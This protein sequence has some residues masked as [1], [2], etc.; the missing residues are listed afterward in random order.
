MGEPF[1]IPGEGHCPPPPPPLP[2][3]PMPVPQ[4]ISPQP[5]PVF[6]SHAYPQPPDQ[7][8]GLIETF[9]PCPPGEVEPPGMTDGSCVMFP[10]KTVDHSHC[11]PPKSTFDTEGFNLQVQ[12]GVPCVPN[13]SFRGQSGNGSDDE[14]AENIEE[15]NAQVQDVAATEKKVLKPTEV[16]QE[17]VA[18]EKAIPNGGKKKSRKPKSA[19]RKRKSK[20]AVEAQTT[21][22]EE[23]EIPVDSGIGLLHRIL[24]P[25]TKYERLS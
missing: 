6:A 18:E 3:L 11:A 15:E 20:P 22:L 1:D 14:N 10:P 23:G 2:P 9:E 13:P 25:V 5:D 21:D 8:G 7:P 12:D 4:W 24:L 17:L 19:S 16:L